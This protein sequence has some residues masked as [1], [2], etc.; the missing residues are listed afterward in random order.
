MTY[1]ELDVVALAVDLPEFGLHKDD[2]GTLVYVYAE[3]QE[4]EVEFVADN[5]DTIALTTLTSDQ[6][7]P[8]NP[9]ATSI[10]REIAA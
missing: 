9:G 3:D 2:L 10:S 8:F 1:R 7:R 5:G 4:F 6:I